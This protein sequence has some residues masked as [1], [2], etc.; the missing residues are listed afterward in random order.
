MQDLKTFTAQ[1]RKKSIGSALSLMAFVLTYI[2][3]V[4]FAFALN[5]GLAYLGINLVILWPRWQT[6]LIAIAMIITG[7]IVLR[8]LFRFVKRNREVKAPLE[9]EINEAD[10]P[11]LFAVLRELTKKVGTKMPRRVYLIPDINASVSYASNFWSLIWPVGKDLRIGWSLVNGVNLSEFKFILAHEFGHFAQGSMILG[12]YTYQVNRVLE[13]LLLEPEDRRFNHDSEDTGLIA[14]AQNIGKGIVNGMESILRGLFKIIN[15]RYA[16]L[17]RQ[18]EFHADA[19]AASIY[20][21]APQRYSLKRMPF[22]QGSL[23]L[24]FNFYSRGIGQKYQAE[25]IF[26]NHRFVQKLL[27]TENGI[28]NLEGWAI[29][30]N[31]HHIQVPPSRIEFRE[32]W[33]SHP[34][35]DERIKSVESFFKAEDFPA[36]D[37]RPATVLFKNTENLEKELSKAWLAL[38]NEGLPQKE[39]LKELDF[40]EHFPKI[41]H[42]N[43]L[44]AI[45]NDYYNSYDPQE[46]DFENI[47]EN[48]ESTVQDLFKDEYLQTQLNIQSM[49]GDLYTLQLIAGKT[50]DLKSFLYQGKPH[51]RLDSGKLVAALRKEIAGSKAKLQAQDQKIFQFFY[52]LAQ[53]QGQAEEL[54][55]HYVRWQNATVRDEKSIIAKVEQYLS[56]LSFLQQQ[57]P[58]EQIESNFKALSGLDKHFR[59][60]IDSVLKEK[61]V[62]ES[63]P[64]DS[65]KILKRFLD[66]KPPYFTKPDYNN[67]AIDHLINSLQI[68][69]H[70]LEPLRRD[71]LKKAC[72]NFN[73]NLIPT[74][75]L[76]KAEANR[77]KVFQ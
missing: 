36:L 49:E 35:E 55:E 6:I 68:Y 32:N 53:S 43:R 57:T 56:K 5:I 65:L 29:L 50:L 41:Y 62:C 34:E 76:K 33:A 77:R 47:G 3:M 72:L 15:R 40:E 73:A 52:H 67:E 20:G 16:D 2:L 18:M 27:I 39:L 70:I 54:K 69:L 23:E 66:L 45:F 60:E 63:I 24:S 19:I 11:E 71:K 14:V 7:I 22:I 31:P 26:D 58:Y 4:I 48:I 44:P 25:N 21:P 28:P 64:D 13:N 74:E 30:D 37:F 1:I 17:S 51:K 9:I 8:Y 12:S 61:E 75:V 42:S 46:I 38:F 59:A 10:Q